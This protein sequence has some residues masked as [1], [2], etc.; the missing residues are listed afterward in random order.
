LKLDDK[1]QLVE[2]LSSRFAKAT[3]VILT[4]YKGLNVPALSDLRRR[5]KEAG[6]EYRVVKNTLMARAS[7]NTPVAVLKGHFKGPGAVAISTDDPVAPAKILA[8]F[9]D[10]SKKLEIKAGVLN[11]R[12]IDFNEIRALAA[13]PA[14]EVLLGR[15]LSVMVGVPTSFVRVLSG[16]PR[17]L[18]NVLVA[19]KEKKDTTDAPA[20]S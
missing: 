20:A 14:R 13:L 6:I 17:G 19:I 16:V 2:E 11:G 5:L 1:K 10:E 9:S 3:V 12:L 8:K 15:L 7:E 18:L 4:D